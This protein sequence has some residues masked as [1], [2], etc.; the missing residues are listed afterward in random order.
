MYE[1]TTPSEFQS[2][3]QENTLLNKDSHSQAPEYEGQHESHQ[4][5]SM[6]QQE[7]A[8]SN[9]YSSQKK[10]EFQGKK[11]FLHKFRKGAASAYKKGIRAKNTLTSYWA[12][13]RTFGSFG[14]LAALGLGRAAKAISHRIQKP[15]GKTRS[16]PTDQRTDE[17][18]K[19]D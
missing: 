3:Q 8:S 1:Q 5:P 9:G 16:T 10:Q 18:G 2:A 7:G 4:T 11:G 14:A 17:V 13:S 15:N 12:L 19:H 6:P